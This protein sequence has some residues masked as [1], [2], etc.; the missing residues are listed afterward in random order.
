MSFVEIIYFYI[1]KNRTF[2]MN[3]ID[4]LIIVPVAWAAYKGFSNGLVI[5]LAQ[6]AAL[7]LGV[8]IAVRFSGLLYPLLVDQ[9]GMGP[10]YT[11][12][13]SFTLLFVAV[14][15]SVHLVARL[16]HRMLELVALGLANRLAGLLFG[17]LKVL[18]ILSVLF[19]VVNRLDSFSGFIGEGTKKG[20]LLYKPVSELSLLI[21]P[22]LEDQGYGY[23]SK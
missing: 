9:L 12:V 17:A 2:F 21:Y 7:V 23:L 11:P 8:F 19:S 1:C 13:I 16:V 10:K 3:Y 5:E 22:D 18:F 20:S 4:I 6:L 14:V 15:I